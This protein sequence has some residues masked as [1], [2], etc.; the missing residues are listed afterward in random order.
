MWV[1]WLRI[2]GEWWKFRPCD[3]W[4]AALD[5]ACTAARQKKRGRYGEGVSIVVLWDGWGEPRGP[6]S[7][8]APGEG[9]PTPQD[10]S[11]SEEHYAHGAPDPCE[12][13]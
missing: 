4:I 3:E 13:L 7:W 11:V 10:V 2:A 5:T 6:C 8:G 12:G 1:P 9:E